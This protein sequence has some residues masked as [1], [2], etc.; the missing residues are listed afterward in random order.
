MDELKIG[1]IELGYS[2][3]EWPW[4]VDWVPKNEKR[5]KLE[6]IREFVTQVDQLAEEDIKKT[7]K[8]E[9]SHYA[10]TTKLSADLEA[11]NA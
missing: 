8:L 4:P 1:K 9:G 10:A 2:D 3:H 7:G 6:I 5:K 11:E